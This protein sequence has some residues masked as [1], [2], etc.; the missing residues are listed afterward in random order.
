MRPAV[1]REGDGVRA[2]T[3]NVRLLDL[4][5]FH[6]FLERCKQ[7]LDEYAW[8]LRTCSAVDADGD[9]RTGNDPCDCG[10][11]EALKALVPKERA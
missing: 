3:V 4:E 6:A 8:H 1:A 10:Y 9:W 7:F 2:A 11:E 5:E